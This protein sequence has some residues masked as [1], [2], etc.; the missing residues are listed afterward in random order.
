MIFE[1]GETV[2]RTKNSGGT[3]DG[4]PNMKSIATGLRD[5]ARERNW[6]QCHSPKNLAMALA[7]E[8]GDTSSTMT[9]MLHVAPAT[10][11]RIAN[12]I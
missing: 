8:A 6:D 5:F 3:L 10:S 1:L 9:G 4:R 11:S 12:G 2:I 7:S